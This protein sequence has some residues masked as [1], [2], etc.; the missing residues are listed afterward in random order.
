MMLRRRDFIQLAAGAAAVPAWPNLAAALDYP[1]RPVRL[2][3]GYTAGS[4]TDVVARLMAQWLSDRLGQSFI[5]ENRPG[6]GTNLAVEAVARAT[7]DGSTLLLITVPTMIGSALYEN[8]SYSF[9]RDIAPIASVG[10]TPFVVVVNPSFAPKTI[11]ELIAYAKANPGKIN[12]ASQGTG[13]LTH[14]AGEMFKM[15]AGVDML[16]V[17]Y[18]GEVQAQ[19][20]LLSGRAQVMFEPIITTVAHIRAGNM[21]ALAV[22]TPEPI[23]VLP[24]VPTVAQ[25]VPGYDVEGWIGIG[26][27][28]ATPAEVIGK[29]NAEINAGLA[30]DRIRTKLLELGS[31]PTKLTPAEYRKQIAG[32]VDKLTK[33]IKFAGIK[34]E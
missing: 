27:P 20:D 5:V 33:A 18:R 13:T 31:V 29:L 14:I 21:R 12:M 6:V 34:P 28:A 1:A 3:V 19:G 11:P 7:A 4:A 26:A 30:D 16:H 32:V 8:L 25:F 17:P 22:T 2:I 9:V 24:G 23:D 10:V 15:M